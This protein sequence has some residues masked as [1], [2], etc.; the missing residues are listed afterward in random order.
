[1]NPLA[2]YLLRYIPHVLVTGFLATVA[3]LAKNFVKTKVKA[4]EEIRKD[5]KDTKELVDKQ[6]RNHLKHIEEYTKDSKETLQRMEVGQA[7]MSGYLKAIA[8]K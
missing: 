5:I 1:M 3:W 2:I 6:N 7:E 4:F 8:E